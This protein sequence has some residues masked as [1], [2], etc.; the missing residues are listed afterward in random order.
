LSFAK[1]DFDVLMKIRQQILK[2]Y[3]SISFIVIIDTI[4][5]NKNYEF[6]LNSKIFNDKREFLVEFR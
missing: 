5:H 1:L 2:S 3:F 6:I 4:L